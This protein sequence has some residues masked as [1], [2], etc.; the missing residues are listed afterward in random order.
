MC[1]VLRIVSAQWFGWTTVIDCYFAHAGTDGREL[2]W[3][4]VGVPHAFN[5]LSCHKAAPV[6]S[7]ELTCALVSHVNPDATTPTTALSRDDNIYLTLP[8]AQHRSQPSSP[9]KPRVPHYSNT[10][11][12]TNAHHRASRIALAV[13]WQLVTLIPSTRAQTDLHTTQDEPSDVCTRAPES[14][15]APVAHFPCLS[16]EP[17]S[18]TA[19]AATSTLFSLSPEETSSAISS[20]ATVT[21]SQSLN[22]KSDNITS[23]SG[24]AVSTSTIYTTLREN[25]PATGTST[26]PQVQSMT[27]GTLS[28]SH[29]TNTILSQN[30][31]TDSNIYMPTTTLPKDADSA[32][33]ATMFPVVLQT[34]TY[35]T[36]ICPSDGWVE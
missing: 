36:T 24:H 13:I 25:D 1:A 15:G 11:A 16:L 26:P 6:V 10:M 33:N 19:A 31:T 18:T 17:L 12:K 35:T 3:I 28:S 21:V 22:S 7:P 30:S 27:N 14:T 5:H 34:V 29:A 2:C 23:A 32:I 8:L 20:S 9:F 4:L